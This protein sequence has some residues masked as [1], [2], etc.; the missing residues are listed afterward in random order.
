MTTQP[1]RDDDQWEGEE[2]L[3]LDEFRKRRA[4][5]TKFPGEK[6]GAGIVLGGR[7]DWRDLLKWQPGKTKKAPSTPKKCLE[8][9]LTTLLHC[10]DW[11]GVVRHNVFTD[12]MEL[13]GALP[14][15]ESH[16]NQD[17]AGAWRDGPALWCAAWFNSALGFEPSNDMMERSLAEVARSNPYHPVRDYLRALKWDGTL[18]TDSMLCQM[19]GAENSPANCAIGSKWLISAVARVMRPGCQVDHMLVLEGPQGTRKSTALR[20]LVGDAWFRNSPLDLRDKDAMQALRGCWVYEFDELDSFRGRDATR[21]KSF[22]TGRVDSYRPP[23]GRHP[24]DV[25]RQCAF[26]GSTNE[27]RYLSDPTGNRRFWPVLCGAIDIPAL[28]AARDQLWAEAFHRFEAGELWYVP[29]GSIADALRALQVDRQEI[30]PWVEQLRKWLEQLLPIKRDEGVTTQ[31]AMESGLCLTSA[32]IGK[33]EETR[34]GHALRTLGWQP[35]R[36]S[37]RGIRE[38]RYYPAAQPQMSFAQPTTP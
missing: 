28:L 37:K 12:R 8:N 3:S 34:V 17:A 25:A 26:A 13:A 29:E 36:E 19:F 11:Q 30:D 35:R 31:Q 16:V 6:Q 10:P 20:T 24:I 4:E 22:I 23:Y 1:P 18:R 5:L 2:V 27:E 38:Y 15:A 9:V 7:D 33:R 21:V 32:G 14:T